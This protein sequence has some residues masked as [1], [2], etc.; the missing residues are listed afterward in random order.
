MIRYI[1][2]GDQIDE[3]TDQFAFFNTVTGRFLEFAG[4]QCWDDEEEFRKD[5][6]STP[7]MPAFPI[8]RFLNLVPKR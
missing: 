8:E 3:D 6:E 7:A 5:Y 4:Q 2:I 1:R